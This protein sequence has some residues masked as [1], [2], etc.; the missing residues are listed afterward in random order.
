VTRR[1]IALLSRKRFFQ[2][3]KKRR[4]AEVKAQVEETLARGTIMS[5]DEIVDEVARRNQLR[6]LVVGDLRAFTMETEMRP[7]V[8]GY[9][10]PMMAYHTEA[11]VSYSGSGALWNAHP[12][13]VNS[14]RL[15]GVVEKDFVRLHLGFQKRDFGHAEEW[16]N[17]EIAWIRHALASLADWIVVSARAEPGIRDLARECLKTLRSES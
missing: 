14:P 8:T 4:P 13:P 15:R 6:P 3:W 1:P 16:I 9:G 11:L 10:D 17:N 5:D 12:G 7:Y 2:S